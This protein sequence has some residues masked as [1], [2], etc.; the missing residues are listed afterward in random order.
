M[1]IWQQLGAWVIETGNVDLNRL[2]RFYSI[3]GRWVVVILI[4]DKDSAPRNLNDLARFKADC[5]TAGIKCGLWA[6]GWGEDAAILAK[7]VSDMAYY[8]KLNP[9]VLDLEQAYKAPNEAKLP[10]LLKECRRLMPG[11]S[12]G[13]TSF[14]FLDRAMIWNGRTMTPA[15]SYYDLKIRFLP[16]HYTQYDIKYSAVY[17][18]KDLKENGATDGNIMDAT[19]P[20]GRGVPLGY[21]HGCIEVTGIDTVNGV[22]ADLAKG[23]ADLTAAKQYGFT[24]GFQ[25]YTL[26][27]VNEE[28]WDMIAAHKGKLFLVA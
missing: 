3:G 5:A 14:G 27:N 16:E 6:N 21:V 18:M 9:V 7:Q 10:P 15:L 23:L 11:K 4:G 13:V 17:C 25:V 12:I 2:K 26:E 28:E 1:T 22:A 19:A 24:F 8:F 20:G